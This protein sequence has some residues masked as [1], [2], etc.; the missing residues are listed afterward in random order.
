MSGSDRDSSDGDSSDRDSSPMSLPSVDDV[1]A[2]EQPLLIG[3]RHH[4]PAMASAI[5]VLL[6][7]FQP[8]CI[9][10]ELPA[11]LQEWIAW[12]GHDDLEA[13]VALSVTDARFGYRNGPEPDAATFA[14]YPFADFS[15]ELVAIR[16]ANARSVPVVAVDLPVGASIE[17][18]ED[19][20][21]ADAVAISEDPD[22]ASLPAFQHVLR[23]YDCD[24]LDDLWDRL[25]E[26][27]APGSDAE[28]IRRAGLRLGMLLRHDE[29]F[30][31]VGLRDRRREMHMRCSI[32]DLV[33]NGE[34][35]AAVVGS[36]HAATLIGPWPQSE[37]VAA[38]ESDATRSTSA[39]LVPYRFDLF[40]SRSGYPAGI[41]DPQWQQLSFRAYQASDQRAAVQAVVAQI[42]VDV[43]R[44]LRARGLVVSTPD[45]QEAVRVARDLATLRGLPVPA[46]RELIE[47]IQTAYVHGE[48]LGRGRV[49]G[50]AMEQVLVGSQSGRLPRSAPRSGLVLSIEA[51]LKALRLPN[52]AS[53]P[54][55]IRL[56]PWRS[57]ID[58]HRLIAINRLQILGIPYAQLQS[59]GEVGAI[60]YGGST[61]Q[62][63]D[64]VEALT[65]RWLIRWEPSTDAV[66]ALNAVFG[67]RLDTAAEGWLRI[68]LRRTQ[69]GSE[70]GDVAVSHLLDLLMRSAR[71]IFPALVHEVLLAV[72]TLIPTTAT[73]RELLDVMSAVEQLQ[74]GLVPGLELSSETFLLLTDLFELSFIESLPFVE[75][76][77]GSD[78]PEDVISLALLV[79]RLNMESTED[80]ESTKPGRNRV[81]IALS[82]MSTA[83]SSLMQGAG[84]AALVLL[85]RLE[86]SVFAP[87]LGAWIAAATSVDK[88]RVL[89]QRMRGVLLMASSAVLTREPL[90]AIHAECMQLSDATFLQIVPSLREGFAVLSTADRRRVL[91]HLV[92]EM[93][94]GNEEDVHDAV[95]GL[96]WGNDPSQQAIWMLADLEADNL[97]RR[98]GLLDA[99][100]PPV[101][102]PDARTIELP[103]AKRQSELSE[104]TEPGWASANG[105]ISA[106]DRWRLLLGQQREQL[107]TPLAKRAGFALDDLY[108]A[109]HGEGSTDLDQGS[110]GLGD[111]RGAGGGTEPSFP[112]VRMWA[113]ELLDVFGQSVR[114]EI[115]GRAA[116]AG[117]ISAALLLDPDEVQ[118]SVALLTEVLSMRGSLQPSQLSTLRRIVDRVV[119]DLVKELATKLRPA[120]TGAVTNRS[121]RRGR[122]PLDMRRTV[123]DNLRNVT[124]ST[125]I[126]DNQSAALR[127]QRFWFRERARRSLD[128]R[129]IFVIDV[130]GSMEASM[131][132]SAMMAA[133]I[134]ALPAVTSHFLAFS[135]DVVDFSGLVDDPLGLLLSVNIGGGTN[136]GQALKYA[137][138]LVTVPSRTL[139]LVVSDFEEGGSIGAL[140]RE[141]R[142]LNESGVRLLGL[143]ALDDNGKPRVERRIAELTVGAGMPIASL[144]PLEVA[145]WVGEKI[146]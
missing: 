63:P 71:G 111:S 98:S 102:T 38:L 70:D 60:A 61:R 67:T 23:A 124:E 91:Q 135:T 66:I 105:S 84:V 12:L 100:P 116:T 41:R 108:G 77:S 137:Q 4:S 80:V 127:F 52:S 72:H 47:G 22:H 53:E 68:A 142:Q 128:W 99:N 62:L 87:T 45:A 141:V 29:T 32:S 120:L 82:E 5:P 30:R 20:T 125:T 97:V 83:G 101:R 44:R 73:F 134:N 13:P 49:V 9:A 50:L 42:T 89:A 92:D 48:A 64:T 132:Y 34:R 104:P 94:A 136:I 40:D 7:R 33:G 2:S 81:L 79:G 107:S 117:R 90:M 112:T 24:D 26:A 36:L 76:V 145:R 19:V 139:M 31:G 106:I 88:R 69:V 21:F 28:E 56:D 93:G 51:E 133:I 113:D 118:P 57:E 59:K 86:P 85:G 126:E 25:V 140:L 1:I 103:A 6:D 16:W 27:T 138:Q 123:N 146:R 18:S 54:T 10:L 14:F 74:M 96:Q 37:A 131:I 130:S 122:G 3:I 17:R 15:P 110:G 46:R 43:A 143:T 129:V 35:V 78:N 65:S 119:A 8:S 115:L 109:G 58:L 39:S 114:E 75:S 95:R 11:D 55:E 144:T 121:S